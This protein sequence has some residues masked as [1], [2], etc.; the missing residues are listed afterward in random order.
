MKSS[1]D[2]LCILYCIGDGEYLRIKNA[3]P[4]AANNRVNTDP[5]LRALWDAARAN[6]TLSRS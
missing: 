4:A 6:E 2:Y 5:A 3:T 1:W